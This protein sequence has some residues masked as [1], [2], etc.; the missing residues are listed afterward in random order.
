MQALLMQICRY[1]KDFVD[2]H[3]S[4]VDISFGTIWRF[5]MYEIITV[6]FELTV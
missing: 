1:F 6:C 4:D 2:D 3:S 5:I